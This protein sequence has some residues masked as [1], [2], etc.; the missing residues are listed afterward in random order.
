MAVAA[1]C[2]CVYCCSYAKVMVV[3][4]WLDDGANSHFMIG[5]K[6]SQG[7]GGDPASWPMLYNALW[8]RYGCVCPHLL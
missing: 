6:G 5:Y 7:D 8:L 4:A 2:V 3:Y 1:V